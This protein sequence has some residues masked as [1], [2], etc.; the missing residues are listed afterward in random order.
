MHMAGLVNELWLLE[1]TVFCSKSKLVIISEIFK[2]QQPFTELGGVGSVQFVLLTCARH[3]LLCPKKIT[4]FLL[5][6]SPVPFYLTG[7]P[8]TMPMEY[9]PFYK[10]SNLTYFY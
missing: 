2:T 8:E 4:N 1:Y 9:L 7:F 3:F 10:F 6:I 5:Q